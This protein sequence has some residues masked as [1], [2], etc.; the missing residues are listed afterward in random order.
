MKIYT[1]FIVIHEDAPMPDEKN[2]CPSFWKA[3][4]FDSDGD[5]YYD[6]IEGRWT[7]LHLTKRRPDERD[8]ILNVNTFREKRLYNPGLQ[9]VADLQRYLDYHKQGRYSD[10]PKISA[11]N[12]LA[13]TS[14]TIETFD[15][16]DYQEYLETVYFF[17][18]YTRGV[19]VSIWELD[20][21]SFKE[22]FLSD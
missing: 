2:F 8:S 4:D 15:L 16:I 6:N 12:N 21:A 5:Y 3:D 18:D 14:L 17:L 20:A 11:M 10:N 19:I 22:E 1:E 7:E 9:E 13:V